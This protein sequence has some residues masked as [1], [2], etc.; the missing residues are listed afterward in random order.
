MKMYFYPILILCLYL[1]YSCDYKED[2][3]EETPID[4]YFTDL[5]NTTVN[6]P[7]HNGQNDFRLNIDKDSTDDVIITFYD[8][9]TSYSGAEGYIKVTPLNGYEILYSDYII[10]RWSWDPILRDSTFYDVTVNI[11]KILHVGDTIKVDDNFTPNP[12]MVHYYWFPTGAESG[13]HSRILYGMAA[14]ANY[15]LIFRNIMGNN[16]KLA[17]LK[18]KNTQLLDGVILNSCKYVDNKGFMIIE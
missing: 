7:S 13:I 12:V 4:K 10:H 9:Y 16:Q 14:S 8:Y 3:V 6:R 18:A 2:Q 1:L 15:I 11:P 17:W 5:H